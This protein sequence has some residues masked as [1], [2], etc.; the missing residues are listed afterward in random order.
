LLAAGAWHR[1]KVY[2][3]KTQM[4]AKKSGFFYPDFLFVL[5]GFAGGF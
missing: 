3:F 2:G 4:D 1:A 5:L